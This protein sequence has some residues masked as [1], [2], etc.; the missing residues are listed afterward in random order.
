MNYKL[1]QTFERMHR[2]LEMREMLEQTYTPDKDT[3]WG[4]DD[5]YYAG[6]NEAYGKFYEAFDELLAD[7]AAR[8]GKLT[9]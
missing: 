2:L 1:E 3:S 8:I 6:L 4:D 5:G 9:K 7:E